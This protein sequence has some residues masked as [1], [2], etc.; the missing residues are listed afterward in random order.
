MAEKGEVNEGLVGILKPSEP[1]SLCLELLGRVRRQACAPVRRKYLRGEKGAASLL[2]FNYLG[3]VE[4]LCS[5]DV[6]WWDR[7]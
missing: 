3:L 5:T 7:L 4:K 2:S 6:G 1:S